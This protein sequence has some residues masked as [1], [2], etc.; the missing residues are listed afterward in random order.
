[1]STSTNCSIMLVLFIVLVLCMH[2]V[3]CSQEGSSCS[4]QRCNCEVNNGDV[5][6]TL[7]E[8]IMDKSLN[9]RLAA[10]VEEAVDS[11]FQAVQ[12]QVNDTVDE[13]IRVSQRDTPGE[14]LQCYYKCMHPGSP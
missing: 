13:K 2:A 4:S 3:I 7:I 5:L 11:K 12:Q 8:A 1:M 6:Q 9:G 14:P 10:S